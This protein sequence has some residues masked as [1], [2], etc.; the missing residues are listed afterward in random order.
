MVQ[1]ENEIGMIPEARDHSPAAEQAYAT[2]VPVCADGYLAKNRASL[3][4]E[5]AATWS[6]AGG[7]TA[8]TWSDIFGKTPASEEIFMALAFCRVHAGDRCRW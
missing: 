3:A 4:P 2:A 5:F 8:G 7:K 6:A 1:V